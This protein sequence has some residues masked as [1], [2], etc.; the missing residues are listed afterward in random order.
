MM[1]FAAGLLIAIALIAGT[2]AGLTLLQVTVVDATADRS[3]H[4]REQDTFVKR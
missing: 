2:A 3:V 1:A 4:V